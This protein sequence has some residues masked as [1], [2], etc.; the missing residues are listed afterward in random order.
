MTRYTTFG[1]MV[2]DPLTFM[3]YDNSITDFVPPTFK[4]GIA[5]HDETLNAKLN[6]DLDWSPDLGLEPHLGLEWRPVEVLALRVGCWGENL[7]AGVSGGAILV[8]PTAGVG[9]LV[10]MGDSLLELDYTLLTDRV[11]PGNFL[12]QISLTGKFL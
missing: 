1:L 12:H 11:E 5:Q 9:I 7:T 8:N 3:S 10:P 2:Q 6:F 4:A